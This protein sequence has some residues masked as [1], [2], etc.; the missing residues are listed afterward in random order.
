MYARPSS[1]LRPPG[2]ILLAAPSWLHPPGCVL[3]AARAILSL[4]HPLSTP[5]FLYPVLT[6]PLPSAQSTA[7]DV[8]DALPS[9]TTTVQ[10]VTTCPG[11][12]GDTTYVLGTTKSDFFQ[13]GLVRQGHGKSNQPQRGCT[14]FT[15]IATYT[16]AWR[17]N[18]YDW[19]HQWYSA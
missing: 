12:T 2:C 10:L 7:K 5:S 11:G 13:I 3:L 15:N 17:T 8:Y 18:C 9:A 16:A 14:Y 1:W 4:P 19:L 6:P